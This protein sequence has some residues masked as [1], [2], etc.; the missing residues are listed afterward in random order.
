MCNQL[1]LQD[2][3]YAGDMALVSDSLDDL[4]GFCKLCTAAA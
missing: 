1:L 4:E 3:E 2:L